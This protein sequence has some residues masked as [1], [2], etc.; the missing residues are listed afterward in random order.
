LDES[1]SGKI[2]GKATCEIEDAL[3]VQLVTDVMNNRC[4]RTQVSV[5]TSISVSNWPTPTIR[6]DERARLP[7]FIGG[8]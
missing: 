2:I 3:I 1:F 6:P 8:G 7:A 5:K 4:L